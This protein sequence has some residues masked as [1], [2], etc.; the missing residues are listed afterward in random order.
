METLQNQMQSLV[1]KFRK[2]QNEYADCGACDS[3]IYSVLSS[4]VRQAK[5]GR[6]LSPK[7]GTTNYWQLYDFDDNEIKHARSELAAKK[8]QE[9]ADDIHDL[10]K[11]MSLALKLIEQY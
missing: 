4:I 2:T 7:K 5:D 8:L 10:V 3:E 1:A 6:D 11:E 9:I